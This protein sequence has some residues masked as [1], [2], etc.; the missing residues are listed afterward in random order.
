[1]RLLQTKMKAVTQHLLKTLI[2]ILLKEAARD[3]MIAMPALV[4]VKTEFGGL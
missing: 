1:M 4:W 3:S 2:N